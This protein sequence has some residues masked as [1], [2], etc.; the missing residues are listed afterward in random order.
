MNHA[1]YVAV[2]AMVLTA[3]NSGESK[4]QFT[5]DSTLAAE[6][7]AAQNTTKPEDGF[8]NNQASQIKTPNSASPQNTH[9]NWDKKIIKTAEVTIELKDYTAYNQKLHTGLKAYGAYIAN[10]EQ[11][12]S[13]ERIVND[14]TI[15]VPVDQFE[16]LMNSFSGDGITLLQK[17]IN[18]QDVTEEMVDTR[19]RIEARKQV[20]ERYLGLLK[21]AKNMKEILEVQ[22]EINSIQEDIE[23]ASGRVG[24]LGHQSAY[25]TVHL[26]YFQYLNG[27]PPQETS[28]FI[29]QVKEGFNNGVKALGALFVLLVSVWPLLLAVLLVLVWLRRRKQPGNKP[30]L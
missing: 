9:D 4:Q 22:K 7:P 1:L 15:K 24:Y 10:E 28:G 2:I 8:V 3:C 23:S 17:K 20:R 29:A 26:Q 13:P 6:I 27:I 11:S 18:S 21:Q 19:S 25:S 5:G 30:V 14:I 12:S 16:N